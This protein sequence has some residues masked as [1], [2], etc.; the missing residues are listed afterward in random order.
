MPLLP[1]ACGHWQ[2]WFARPPSC[3]VCTD[4]RN[5]LPSDGRRFLSADEVAVGQARSAVVAPGV[6]GYWSEPRLGLGSSG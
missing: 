4:M 3:P 1:Y 2:R 6:T 5:A